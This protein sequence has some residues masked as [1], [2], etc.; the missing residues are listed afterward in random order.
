MDSASAVEKAISVCIL[1]AQCIRHPAYHMTYLILDLAV[2]G[3]LLAVL[4]LH[5]DACAESTHYSNILL[6]GFMMSP[7]SFIASR[8]LPILLTT[9]ACLVLG[10]ELSLAHWCTAHSMS[11]LVDFSRYK[12]FPITCLQLKLL[13]SSWFGSSS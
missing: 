11:G 7:L 8:C 3:S 12:S 6:S 5:S 9:S 1:E 2:P 13:D 10:L 4:L